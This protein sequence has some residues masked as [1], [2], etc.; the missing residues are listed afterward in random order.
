MVVL[1]HQT[2]GAKNNKETVL[3]LLNINMGLL[4]GILLCDPLG[5]KTHWR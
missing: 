1:I 5:K 3:S 2:I 4:S